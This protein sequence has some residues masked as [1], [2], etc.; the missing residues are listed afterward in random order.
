MNSNNIIFLDFETGG[1]NPFTCQPVQLSAIVI[2]GRRLNLIDGSLF[3]SYIKPIPDEKC[4]ALGI[5]PIGD[6]ALEINKITREQLEV[7]PDLKVVWSSFSSYVEKYK[8]GKGIFGLPIR[9][10]YNINRFD[11]VILDRI[12]GGNTQFAPG[13]KEPYGFGPW[14][15]DRREQ[16]LFNPRDCIDMMPCYVW[17]WTENNSDIR[18]ISMEAVREWLGIEHDRAHN[19][20]ADVIVGA[21]VLVRFMKLTRS[22]A[23]KVQF[24]KSLAS[25]SDNIK[26]MIDAY[27]GEK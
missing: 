6:E 19:A 3:N 23:P 1:P 2:D 26:K 27:L 10:G 18:S 21:H 20:V 5:E 13:K 9:S 14:D 15:D 22:I 7:A 11:N 25:E 4:E 16:R 12:M 24:E 8:K 17:P